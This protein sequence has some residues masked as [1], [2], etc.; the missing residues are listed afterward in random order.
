MR[1]LPVILAL[2]SPL[3]AAERPNIVVMMADDMGFSDLGCYGSEIETPNLDRLAE[4]GLRFSE[5]YNAARCCPTRAALLTGLYP[6]QAGVGH[7]T[8]DQ[9]LPG[10]RGFLGP[11]TVTIAE[12]LRPAGYR[13]ITVGKWHVGSQRGRWPL[14]RG[15]DRFWGTPQ[16]GGVYFKES[17]AIRKPRIFVDGEEEVEFPENGY[18]TDLFTDHAIRFVEEAVEG[19]QPFFLYFAHIAPHWPLQAWAD[20]IAR[21]AGRYEVGWDEVRAA[22]HRRLVGEGLIDPD[23]KL[24]E[25]DPQVADW[26]SHDEAYR[27]D[28]A[29][30]MAVY[31]AQ[32]DSIDRNLGRLIARLEELGQWENTL[33]LF[34]SDNGCSAEGGPGGFSR[35]R[36]GVPIGA[37]ASYASAGL[38]WANVSD[39][40]FRKFKADTYEGGIATPLIVHWPEGLARR[41]EIEHQPGHVIDLLPTCLAVAEVEFPARRDGEATLAPEGLSLLPAFEGAPLGRGRPLAW[42]HRGNR[43]IRDGDW[44][45]VAPH[46]GDWELYHLAEDRTETRDLAEA[47]PERLER[48][49]TKYRAWAAKCGVEPWPLAGRD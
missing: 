44:K 29:H 45:A 13:T 28:L 30:R 11:R 46:G 8:G 40:P 49:R 37:G 35:G 4:N 25:R 38:E 36:K 1:C 32:I 47:E 7:M 41:G 15:F 21:Y 48:L 16:G 33:F 17:I 23:W 12:A 18:V 19:E 2:L 20:D 34:L 10:Y 27:L 9:G 31:A 5:F 24:S 22:R 43:A 3:L 26:A 6:H 14:D 42:E 39:T